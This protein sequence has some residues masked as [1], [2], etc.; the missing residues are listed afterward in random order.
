[1]ACST[2]LGI[3]KK[4]FAAG[5]DELGGEMRADSDTSLC[6][7]EGTALG[8]TCWTEREMKAPDNTACGAETRRNKHRRLPLGALKFQDDFLPSDL[9]KITFCKE[10]PS[11][12]KLSSWR[13][14]KMQGGD[15]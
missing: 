5:A 12:R 3:K 7:V 6:E 11:R 13:A 2:E 8:E 14:L 9:V 1:M 4:E 10:D 15:E